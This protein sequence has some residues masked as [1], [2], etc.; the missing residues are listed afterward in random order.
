MR[1]DD[2]PLARQG[3]DEAKTR[4]ALSRPTALV[5]HPIF[6][7]PA[8]G[9]HHPLSTGRHGAV[10]D[11][12]EALGWRD[13]SA[14]FEPDLPDRSVLERFH[15]PAYLDA[16]ERA[17][18]ANLAS[19]GDR[20]DFNLG[21]MECPI[22]PGL[23][24]R[25]R[26]TV[27]GS[28]LAARLALDGYVA[29]HPGGGT[30]H[31]RPDRAS[32]FCYLNDPVF[33]IQTLLNAGTERVVY[34]DFDAHHGDGVQDILAA[35]ERVSFISIHEEGRW[36]GTGHP[37]DRLGGRAF[38][39]MVPRGLNDS[40]LDC[41]VQRIVL[42][43][44]EQLAPAG[45][46]MTL[47]ADALKGDPLSAMMLSNVALWRAAEA[48]VARAEQAVILGGGGYN[49]W[50]TA[51]LWAGLWGRLR[52]E[53]LPNVLPETVRAVLE[54]LECDLIDAEDR[55]TEWLTTLCDRANIGPI[56]QAVADI[57]QRRIVEDMG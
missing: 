11:L 23:W 50:T 54:R 45:L 26:A 7:A 14:V 33:A 19:P 25:A 53:E 39:I 57:V 5:T 27:G 16:F 43:T 13:E 35:D 24:E 4:H 47:G 49:P 8:F 3:R 55:E 9:S 46:V 30:H 18:A 10:L 20:R 17:T 52:G 2:D 28:I 56:R 6:R 36:P 31:G 37:D 44:I 40:E 29:F 15:D 1:F 12:I 42:P 32:G 41:L 22:F 34:V 38:N 21:T 51:R 48:C